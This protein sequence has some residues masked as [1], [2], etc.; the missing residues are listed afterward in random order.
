[1]E[2]LRSPKRRIQR[3]ISS[4]PA[5]APPS[6]TTSGFMTISGSHA[7]AGVEAFDIRVLQVAFTLDLDTDTAGFKFEFLGADHNAC[8]PRL[9]R[10]KAATCSANV[11]ASS[12][13]PRA[14]MARIPS[15]MRS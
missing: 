2:K 15:M 8:N 9:S 7:H 1:M 14:T 12:T 4:W 13:W 10:T 11:S 5:R 6:F 3:C